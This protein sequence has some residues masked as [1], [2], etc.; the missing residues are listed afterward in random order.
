MSA[1]MVKHFIDGTGGVILIRFLTSSLFVE[2][3]LG[4]SSFINFMQIQ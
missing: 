2:S 3:L 4:F 1:Q